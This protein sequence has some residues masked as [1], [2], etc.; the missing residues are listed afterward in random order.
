M[1]GILQS[2]NENTFSC[3]FCMSLFYFVKF[4]VY[5]VLCLSV[6]I[7]IFMNLQLV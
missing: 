1:K 4:Y 3:I 7:S 5:I 6:A 2:D